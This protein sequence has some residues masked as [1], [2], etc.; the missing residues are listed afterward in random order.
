MRQ[1]GG[2]L[3]DSGVIRL[4]G[5]AIPL[6]QHACS[7]GVHEIIAHDVVLSCDPRVGV[8]EEFGCE[9]DAAG[10]VISVAPVRRNRCGV[11]PFSPALSITSRSRRRTLFVVSG[12]PLRL[13][14][15]SASGSI[16]SRFLNRARIAAT[17]SCGSAIVS[18]V[19][20]AR[21]Y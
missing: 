12:S 1:G 16:E 11:T 9:V 20:V 6:L 14:N 18:L 10:L 8:P 2:G 4:G 15:R 21:A 13:Q 7:G 5:A 3:P 17:A 19:N